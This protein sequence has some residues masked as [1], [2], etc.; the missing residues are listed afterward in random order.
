V[1]RATCLQVEVLNLQT[2]ATHYSS[3]ERHAACLQ[4]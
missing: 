1:S 2:A 3:F 4:H